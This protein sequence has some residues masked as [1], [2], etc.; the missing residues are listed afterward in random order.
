TYPGPPA[1]R[2]PADSPCGQRLF[3]R[4]DVEE[5]TQDRGIDQCSVCVGP[6]ADLDLADP[7]QVRG[8][9]FAY[10][11]VREW[12]REHRQRDPYHMTEDKPGPKAVMAAFIA[13]WNRHDMST[14]ASLFAEDADF[15]DIFGNWFKD[16]ASIK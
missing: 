11:K 5:R 8:C 1:T 10:R 13:S 9:G 7:R 16:R 14:L 2:W 6:V 12:P 4:L 15:I 3:L